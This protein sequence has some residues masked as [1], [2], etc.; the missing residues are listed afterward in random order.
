MKCQDLPLPKKINKS[1]QSTSNMQILNERGENRNTNRTKQQ[2]LTYTQGKV[3]KQLKN[4]YI[5]LFSVYK[6][7]GCIYVCVPHV[8]R[9]SSEV[10][11]WCWSLCNWKYGSQLPGP[12]V[13]R[14]K[15]G[16]CCKSHKCLNCWACSL[17]PPTGGPVNNF[18]E[19]ILE[20]IQLRVGNIA[21]WWHAWLARVKP[22]VCVSAHISQAWL[23]ILII[24][25]LGRQA[26][27]HSKVQ[28][29]GKHEGFLNRKHE[30]HNCMLT[31]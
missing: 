4:L 16:S 12:Q 6:C 17:Q 18:L 10:R 14:T 22:W 27:G 30:Q 26:Q 19:N 5:Y 31:S 20:T 28:G 8:W 24:P 21:P 9:L 15:P 11:R 23:H 1:T 13:L 2:L 7:F 29:A 25:P 3:L